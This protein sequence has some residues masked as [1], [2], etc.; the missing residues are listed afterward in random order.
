MHNEY[1]KVAGDNTNDVVAKIHPVKLTVYEYYR[2]LNLDE[3]A[4]K[5]RMY[6]RKAYHEL[7][8]TG[9]A[10]KESERFLDKLEEKLRQYR[11]RDIPASDR[12]SI[13]DLLN[14]IAELRDRYEGRVLSVDAPTTLEQVIVPGKA[15]VLKLGSVDEEVADVVVY[16]YLD[17]LLRER[18][19]YFSGESGYPVPVLVVI[20]EAHV[21]IPRNR[22]TLT[23]QVAARIAR[24]GR[25]FGVGLCLVS[26]RPKNIDE[27]ALSQTNNK[28]IL[29]LVEPSDQ[30]YVQQA[31]ETLSEELLDLLPS[32]NTGEAIIL[33]MM[34]PIPA[35]VKIDKA[36][37]KV[38][39]SDIDV[40]GEWLKYCEN[41][42]KEREKTEEY[43][44]YNMF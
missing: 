14:K 10:L 27:D 3:K 24:E 25:K 38:T 36:Q 15:N 30:R 31:S 35:L 23:K 13:A 12:N 42:E 4:T 6:L 32:L 26:Q 17:W 41:K 33:G 21:L 5:Q 40:A 8:D 44:P 20:E 37:H 39:G 29:K 19:R 16:H 34:T 1:G 22:S 2:L 11:S 28:I 43:N 9:E 18:K 7:F